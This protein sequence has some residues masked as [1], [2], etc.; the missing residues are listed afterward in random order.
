VKTGEAAR[1]SSVIQSE[2]R[3]G[4]LVPVA[5]LQETGNWPVVSWRSL[6]L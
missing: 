3:A 2:V 5:S 1:G 6:C 4:P